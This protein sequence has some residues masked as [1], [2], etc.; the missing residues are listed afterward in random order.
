MYGMEAM[1]GGMIGEETA[2]GGEERRADK[3]D[4]IFLKTLQ[5]TNFSL[6]FVN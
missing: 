1:A 3:Q 2:D 4:F 5:K 6:L